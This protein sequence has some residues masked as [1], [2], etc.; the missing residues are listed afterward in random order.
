[1]LAEKL[2]NYTDTYTD[3]EIIH[4]L[5][6]HIDDYDYQRLVYITSDGKQ[7]SFSKSSKKISYASY[8]DE[9]SI[10]RANKG[11]SVF[12][13]I[14]K[15]TNAPSLYINE[16]VVPVYNRSN[17]KIVGFLA[18][19]VYAENFI[20]IL[21][22]NNY[23][24]QGYSYI[25]NQNGDFVIKPAR[26]QTEYTNFFY[27]D[28]DY[29]GTS[30]DQVLKELKIHNVGSFVFK[31][32]GEKYL[33]AFS[34]IDCKDRI[35]FTIVPLK[36]LMLHVERLLGCI[37]FI[38][39]LISALL[40]GLSYYTNKLLKQEQK[41]I[42]EIAFY[43]EVT[44]SGNKN[45]FIL[46]A[47]EI[48]KARKDKNY[49][50]IAMGLSNFKAIKELYGKEASEKILKDV[51]DLI[52]SNIGEESICVRDYDAN[53]IILYNYEKEEFIIKYLIEKIRDE[54][55]LYNERNMKEL[56][57]FSD[58]M[59]SSK[60]AVKFGIYLISDYNAS[61]E[62]LCERAYVA[63]S[64][65]K[66][67]MMRIYRFYD[68]ELKA[69]IFKNKKIEDEMYSAL[70]HNQFKMFLQ[71]KFHLS[72][73]KLY[74]AEALVRWFHPVDGIIPPNDFIPLFEKNGFVMEID[75]YIWEEACKFLAARQKQGKKL[76]PISVNVS[77]LHMNNDGFI[78]CLFLLIKKY[79]IDPKYLELELT[80]S[81][82]FNDEEKFIEILNKLKSFGF[83]I[84][85]DDFGTGYSSLTMLRQLP[86]DIL[87]LDRGFIKDTIT[88]KKGQIVIHSIIDMAKKLDMVTVAEGIEREDQAEFLR[89][90][91]CQIAQGFLYGKP[92][93]SETFIESFLPDEV[94][95]NMN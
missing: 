10:N 2:N 17:T 14:K 60:L 9:D 90:I 62:Q 19:R 32:D 22:F 63:K 12:S 44:G 78:T 26:Y 1:M 71:P 81:A 4:F 37:S 91:G 25:I 84:S 5:T 89:N 13:G 59:I 16:F 93:S 31:M 6:T 49:A 48:L 74:G 85:M 39:F 20:R 57:S 47:D 23:E 92:V 52:F 53:F 8:I 46:R 76:Y 40:L 94:T 36:V 82:N 83:T 33:A 75:R 56:V 68:E 18:S 51:Y 42:Y 3:A 86:F 58:T 27:N 34:D 72:N 45:K 29:V 77:R 11:E 7:I 64:N 61:I 88:D 87:K 73:G 24:E 67:D 38:V 41:T 21:G 35:V 54:I 65:L 80:E 28:I 43:D 30:R 69:K 15:D 79:D 70:E 50:V 55:A 95:S 66:N